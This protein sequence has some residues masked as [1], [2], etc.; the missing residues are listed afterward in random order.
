VEF[1]T[2]GRCGGGS[3]PPSKIDAEHGIRFQA[4]HDATP[5]AELFR[6]GGCSA[7]GGNTGHQFPLW[8]ASAWRSCPAEEGRGVLDRECHQCRG[9]QR[10]AAF[11][12]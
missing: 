11:R 8:L 1:A 7:R 12:S 10:I 6:A 2:G 3:K 4:F 9:G 5:R